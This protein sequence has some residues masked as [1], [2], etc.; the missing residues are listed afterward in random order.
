MLLLA[1]VSLFYLQSLMSSTLKTSCSIYRIL[2]YSA[3]LAWVVF[4]LIGTGEQIKEW[5]SL[6]WPGL[7]CFLV[8]AT[9]Y[10]IRSNDNY[11]AATTKNILFFAFFAFIFLYYSRPGFE[12]FRA[13]IVAVWF[14][15]T[16]ISCV[17]SIIFLQEHPDYARA[18]VS[19]DMY[20][21][22]DGLQTYTMIGF[23]HVGAL[24]FLTPAFL[25]RALGK[26]R[27]SGYES[28]ILIICCL[29]FWFTVMKTQFT[30]A[31]MLVSSAVLIVL[32]I[33]ILNKVKKELR[34]HVCVFL[35]ILFALLI[36][37]LPKFLLS[38][39][40]SD[41]F[42]SV[43]SDRIYSIY[44][45]ITGLDIGNSDLQD[46]LY[47]YSLSLEGIRESKLLGGYFTGSATCGGHSEFG[48]M[49]ALFGVFFFALF[50]WFVVNIFRSGYKY[51]V[52]DL[53]PGFIISY[54]IYF[55]FSLINTSLWTPIGIGLFI[56]LPFSLHEGDLFP[57][58][59][60]NLI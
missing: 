40:E 43:L 7:V 4:A 23:Y 20:G 56:I 19:P 24:S 46:R 26:R 37:L 38:L 10:L 53:R 41:L 60:R 45:M 49:L 42:G 5:L 27:K 44:R 9:L 2:S 58:I 34:L 57:L 28:L 3:M 21:V 12:K 15:E 1:L 35:I 55:I 36:F 18:L 25:Y 8:A 33:V 50:I 17:H 59:R 39:Y 32:M 31:L 22:Y 13:I 29:L 48:D 11:L 6:L 51:T 52:R 16:V 14:L 47:H 30:I 54:V